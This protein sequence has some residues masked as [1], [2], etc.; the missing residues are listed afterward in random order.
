MRIVHVIAEL[1]S[2]GAE[3]VVAELALAARRDGDDVW[4]A[5]AGGR[6]ESGLASVGVHLHRMP[7]A[8]RSAVGAARS[9]AA[10]LP[11]RRVRPNVIHAHNV[12]AAASA[13]AGLRAPLK[14]PPVLVTFHGVADADYPK[15]ASLLRRFSDLVAVVD[16]SIGERLVSQGFPR[17]RLRTVV[18]AVTRPPQHDRDD[19]RRRLG[20]PL[21]APVV[22]NVAR[23]VEQKRHDVLLEAWEHVPAPAVLL[24]AGDGPLR[25]TLRESERVRILG[26]RDDVDRLLAAADV[27]TLSSDWEGLPMALLEA[28]SCGLPV[29]ATAV[30][31][32]VRACADAGVLVPRR[33]P[34][35]LGEAL[36]ALCE[37]AARRRA[38]GDAARRRVEEHY[39]PAALAAGYKALYAELGTVAPWTSGR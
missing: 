7:L 25:S 10:L 38:L 28:M 15:A 11:L 22:L 36:R 34:A 13:Y 24:V 21:D 29:V 3:T 35:A 6:H 37:D 17:D 26:D 19:V 32:V 39:S 27:F 1:G 2:G 18:N 33:D 9:A 23:L 12:G 4:V 30:D 16:D 14:A 8:R 20:I 31:G 5:S